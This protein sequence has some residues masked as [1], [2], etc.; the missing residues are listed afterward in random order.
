MLAW[1]ARACAAQRRRHAALA[2]GDAGHRRD[3]R[4]P[5]SATRPGSTGRRAP[6]R[7]WPTTRQ[8]D[9]EAQRAQAQALLG[10]DRRRS[11]TSTA[12]SPPRT[13]A[14]R[15]RCRR[16]RR[17]R[18]AAERDAGAQQP[19]PG[20]RAAADRDRPAQRRRARME[21][22][23]ARHERPRAARR[24]AARLRARG[25]GPLHQHQRPHARR[26]R[27]RA[28]LPDA[29]PQRGAR[30]RAATSASTRPTSTG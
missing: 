12:R 1:K 7:R 27:R 23:A 9:G 5:S 2:A 13:W 11:C 24:G 6:C 15:S 29:V 28:A 3:E 21:L 17:R 26:D 8:D 10:V 19:R 18:R 4:R 22:L 20:A 25:L 16:G 14:S 30:A